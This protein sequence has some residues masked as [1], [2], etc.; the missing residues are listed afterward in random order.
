MALAGGGSVRTVAPSEHTRTNATII[1]RF[2]PVDIQIEREGDRA[3]CVDV[4]PRS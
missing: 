4:S 3:W 1:A 2:L